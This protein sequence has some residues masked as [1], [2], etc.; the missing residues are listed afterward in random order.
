MGELII[1]IGGAIAS[2]SSPLEPPCSSN[3]ASC[4][5]VNIEW[6]PLHNT[7]IRR[8]EIEMVDS[9]SSPADSGQADGEH[10]E[11][12]RSGIVA[13]NEPD[14]DEQYSGTDKSYTDEQHSVR[15]NAT[16]MNNK[17][18]PVIPRQI[19]NILQMDRGM[20]KGLRVKYF[21]LSFSNRYQF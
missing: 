15:V 2:P 8:S 12:H 17:T 19:S 21:S 4:F 20:G 7:C 16:R 3:E 6:T 1:G 11:R 13:P 5:M 10:N 9:P 14:T 18:G